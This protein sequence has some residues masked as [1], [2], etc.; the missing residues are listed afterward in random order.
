MAAGRAVR[1]CGPFTA[2]ATAGPCPTARRASP[3]TSGDTRLAHNVSV[4]VPVPV[5]ADVPVTVVH[6]V[7]VVPVRHR[8]MPAPVAMLVRVVAMSGVPARFTLV[9]MAV[10]NTME[11]TV[12]HVVHV[13]LVRDGHVAAALAV[14]MHV[15]GMGGMC[16]GHDVLRSFLGSRLRAFGLRHWLELSLQR[17]LVQLVTVARPVG[18]ETRPMG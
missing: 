12:V 16:C 1:R 10:V 5:M 2:G 7:H 9:H 17:A 8:D 14:L 3:G 4:V 11:V 13:V 6:V 18:C 15:V